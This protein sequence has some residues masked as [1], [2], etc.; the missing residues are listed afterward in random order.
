MLT[1]VGE[2]DQKTII[3]CYLM[4]LKDARCF[5]ALQW[6]WRCVWLHGREN[7]VLENSACRCCSLPF[8]NCAHL[9]KITQTLPHSR[10]H[11]PSLCVFHGYITV[12]YLDSINLVVNAMGGR[13]VSKSAK[14]LVAMISGLVFFCANCLRGQPLR[15]Q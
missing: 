14:L 10:D 12:V 2:C 11:A 7:F 5:P 8:V 13:Q 4:V 3:L 6:R 15:F 9:C 1:P